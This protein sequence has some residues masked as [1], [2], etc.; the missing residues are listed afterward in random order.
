MNEHVTLREVKARF[1]E[2]K[3]AYETITVGE[4]RTLLVSAYG[5][6]AIGPFEG[7]DGESVL[8]LPGVF[9]SKTKFAA[10]V[11]EHGWLVGAERFW[12]QPELRFYCDAPEKFDETYT[13][14]PGIDPGSWKV[15]KQED[16][17]TLDQTSEFKALD[18]GSIK[19]CAIVRMYEPAANP[20]MFQSSDGLKNVTYYGFTQHIEMMDETPD[21]P[22]PLEPWLLTNVNP[23]GKIIVPYFGDFRYDDYYEPVGDLLEDCGDYATLEATGVNKYKVAFKSATTF[24]RMGYLSE[25]E[26]GYRLM[27]RNYYNDPSARYGGEPWKRL[28]ER[29]TSMY[30][31]NDHGKDGGGFAEFE[32]SFPPVHPVTHRCSSATSL[33]FFEGSQR[34]IDEIITVLL[35]IY[36]EFEE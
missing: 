4:G 23:G 27:I 24:G 1:D 19:R 2:N 5:G 11:K 17:I 35:G 15:Q 14:Q 21:N 33:W 31:Y 12:I 29:G 8:W 34:E 22:I 20:L 26:N 28:G 25:T 36:Y 6:R 13:V 32:N 10:F 3:L 7:E 18:D 9:K 16:L 30:F